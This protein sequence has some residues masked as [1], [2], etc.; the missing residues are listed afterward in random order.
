MFKFPYKDKFLHKEAEEEEREV[1]KE[2]VE[3]EEEEEEQE[4]GSISGGS[5][6]CTSEKSCGF[7]IRIL[8]YS[9]G[10]VQ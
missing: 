10:G 4:M 1:E 7:V 5:V 3:E 9:E 2:E 6:C 8:R